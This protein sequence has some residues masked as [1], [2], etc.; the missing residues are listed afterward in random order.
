VVRVERKSFLALGENSSLGEL[1]V[2]GSELI[3]EGE[4]M[5]LE[6]EESKS[7]SFENNKTF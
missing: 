2:I 3:L 1:W 6:R 7:K 5:K 4:S